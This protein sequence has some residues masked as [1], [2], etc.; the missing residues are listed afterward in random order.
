MPEWRKV[1]EAED[2]DFGGGAW[3]TKTR[4]FVS[5]S[6]ISW[7][8]IINACSRKAGDRQNVYLQSRTNAETFCLSPALYDG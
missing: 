6:K 7:P 1:F 8:S 5:G 4:L 2:S 3:V